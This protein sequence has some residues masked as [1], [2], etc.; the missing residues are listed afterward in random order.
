MITKLNPDGLEVNL[1]NSELI[2]EDAGTD[3]DNEV[4][5][6]GHDQAKVR[7]KEDLGRDDTGDPH[8]RYPHDHG[9][10]PSQSLVSCVQSW[11]SRSS[12][13][14]IITSSIT[15]KK[16]ITGF[17]LFPTDPKT[18]PNVRQKNIMP[19][20]LVPDLIYTFIVILENTV[21]I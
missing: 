15:V 18:V 10:H 6:L 20:V 2:D 1:E 13:Y 5:K 21:M 11:V 9:H 14:R 7:D 8:W 4:S 16:S 3:S 17:A 12:S 19:R